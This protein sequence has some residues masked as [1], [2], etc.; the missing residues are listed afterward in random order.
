LQNEEDWEYDCRIASLGTRLYYCDV[1]ISEQRGHP[2]D[3]ISRYGW[4]DPKRLRDRAAAHALIFGHAK[5]AGITAD[6]P[7]MKHFARELFMLSRRCGASGLSY[8]SRELFMLARKASEPKRA[9]GWDFRLYRLISAVLGWKA[10]GNMVCLIEQA[11]GYAESFVGKR[12][13]A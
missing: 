6:V 2:G 1:L 4:T 10:A 12:S 7:E 13:N 8:E 3:Q 11:K 9:K 5:K